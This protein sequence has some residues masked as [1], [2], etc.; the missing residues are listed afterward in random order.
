M[1]IFPHWKTEIVTG[2]T[3]DALN[4]H[5]TEEVNFKFGTHFLFIKINVLLSPS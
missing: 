3:K 2:R 4:K 1:N 5:G